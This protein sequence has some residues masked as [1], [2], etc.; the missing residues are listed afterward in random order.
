MR[1]NCRRVHFGL[2]ECVCEVSS[3]DRDEIH[4]TATYYLRG[5]LREAVGT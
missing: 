3:A 1:T 4:V 2:L 5:S